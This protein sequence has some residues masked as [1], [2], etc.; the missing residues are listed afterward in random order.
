M[1]ASNHTETMTTAAATSEVVTPRNKLLAYFAE[2]GITTFDQVK[3]EISRWGMRF[4]TDPDFPGLGKIC[5]DGK[6]D[7]TSP[8]YH[9]SNGV[10]LE[11][12]EVDGEKKLTIAAHSLAG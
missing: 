11:E 6:T 7:H 2:M 3:S 9:F 10:M 12:T 8:I 4:K 5:H 1:S